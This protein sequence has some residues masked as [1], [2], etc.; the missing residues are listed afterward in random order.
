[1]PDA[2][3]A[4]TTAFIHCGREIG[5]RGTERGDQTE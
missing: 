4:A 2:E 1:L 3:A 5:S